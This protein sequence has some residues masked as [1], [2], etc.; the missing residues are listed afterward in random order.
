MV[1]TAAGGGLDRTRRPLQRS[2]VCPYSAGSEKPGP[3]CYCRGVLTEPST[4]TRVAIARSTIERFSG[5]KIAIHLPTWP[6]CPSL[7]PF[8]P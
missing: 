8:K 3:S 6:R 4:R 7:H 1:E 5:G 2:Q